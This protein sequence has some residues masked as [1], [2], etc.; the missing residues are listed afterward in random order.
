MDLFG[1]SVEADDRKQVSGLSEQIICSNNYRPTFIM[2]KKKLRVDSLIIIKIT[3]SGTTAGT[4]QKARE[5]SS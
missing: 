1:E 5:L 3:V 2:N 4:S